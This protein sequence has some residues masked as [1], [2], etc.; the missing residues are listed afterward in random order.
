MDNLFDRLNG[1]FESLDRLF[2]NIFEHGRRDSFYDPDFKDAWI[3]LEDYLKKRKSEF[4]SSDR[5]KQREETHT[6]G[7]EHLRHDYENLEVNFGASQE[8]VSRAYKK[9]MKKYHPDNYPEN[10]EKHKLATE[11]TKKL[12]NSY[13]KIK[14]TYKN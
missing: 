14:K 10:S 12:N 5:S 11:I 8:D 13:Q 2:D 9:L 6:T 7:F 3:E 4:R 1:I